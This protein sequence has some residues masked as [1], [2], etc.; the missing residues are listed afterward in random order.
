MS[1]E[2]SA[3]ALEDGSNGDAPAS[4]RSSFS[5]TGASY[6][7]MVVNLLKI[8][9]GTGV[10]AVPHAFA[11]GGAVPCLGALSVLLV[12][13]DWSARRLLACRDLLDEAGRA[14]LQSGADSP[15][16][17][18]A[19]AAAGG[20][21][22]DAVEGLLAT[23]MFGVVVA[24]LVALHDFV[25]R[26][27]LACPRGVDVG[28]A[29]A[30]ALPLSLVDDLGALAAV[31]AAGL[32]ALGASFVIIVGCEAERKPRLL[33]L[34]SRGRHTTRVFRGDEVAATPRRP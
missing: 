30:M 9:V 29:A 15:L 4:R 7:M 25:A 6:G 28:V 26:T 31:G 20:R 23:L 16:A 18:L 17:A 13:N 5:P 22:A 27:P 11:T 24:Y 1:S 3:L 10:L 34:S 14:R 32:V 33:L 19:R 21:V 8:C 2:R 12:W